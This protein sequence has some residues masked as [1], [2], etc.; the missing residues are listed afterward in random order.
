[1]N[2]R[3][4]IAIG[5]DEKHAK[6]EKSGEAFQSQTRRSSSMHLKKTV[7]LTSL[8][9]F[10][11]NS[12]DVRYMLESRKHVHRA[13]LAHFLAVNPWLLKRNASNTHSHAHTHTQTQTHQHTYTN[14]EAAGRMRRL[15]SARLRTK[16][17]CSANNAHIRH[18][19][20]RTR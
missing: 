15:P 11:L 9:S 18:T 6:D 19:H 8:R 4:V 17:T 7:L 20:A 10:K 14:T 2:K 1:M 5:D 3:C 12:N 13:P 16:G